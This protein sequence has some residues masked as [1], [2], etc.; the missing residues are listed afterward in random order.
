[1]NEE[2]RRILRDAINAVSGSWL[3]PDMTRAKILR[4]WGMEIGDFCTIEMNVLPATSHHE[5]GPSN[6]R[7]EPIDG[8]P[9]T[10]G[11]GSGLAG[12]SRSCPASPWAPAA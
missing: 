3:L 4:L 1:M 5:L 12:T 11:N 7:A 10:I 9:V 6:R 8:R 2:A